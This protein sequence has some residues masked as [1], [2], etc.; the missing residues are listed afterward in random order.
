MRDF[1]SDRLNRKSAM[2]TRENG[3]TME[4]RDFLKKT[5]AG[6]I[7]AGFPGIISG[8]T[9]TNAVKVGLVGAG[10][11]GSGAAAQALSADPNN[12]LT[13]VADI[14]EAIVEQAANR[15]R[16]SE[17]F[18]ARVKID[19]AFF[20]LDA[21]DKV[22][23]SGVDVVLLATPP[24]FRPQH[25]TAAVNANKH[26]FAEKPCATDSPG[27]REVIAAQKLAQ[28]KNLA[29]VSGFC[30]RYNNMIQEAVQQVH[31]GALGRLVA[32]YSTYYTNP[33]KPIPPETE[34]PAGMSDIE[35]QIRHWYNFTWLC[36][37]SLVE[38]AVHN[39][40][41]IMWI[42][43]DQPPASCV[44]VGG[45]AVPANGG[46]IYDHFDANYVYPNG[47]RVFLVNRQATGCYNAT[48][49]YVMGTDGTLLLG[50][51]PARIEAP[52][53][54]VK[55]QF[56][57]EPYDMY[58]REHDVLFS[59]IRSGK[60]KNDDLNLATSTLLAIMGRHAA[61]SGQQVTWEQALNSE[62]SLVPKP[63][64]WN[65]KHEVPGLAQP[66]RSKVF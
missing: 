41:K 34:R 22:I 15:L 39:T 52:G 18:G 65:G 23:N 47:Y 20:G 31:N 24:G 1:V 60:P 19:Q 56:Q 62:V 3:S 8:Q 21:Y 9:V 27:V 11:R 53:G 57:G 61:Y 58:Q 25:L 46:N 55:W 13:A 5:G 43:K 54:Q 16:K 64:D 51:G 66:G 26:V 59:S 2:A 10:G 36:G 50:N 33:V 30:W 38:Q 29:L 48:H 63:V 44:A 37:D 28:T 49:D 12:E 17:R 40:D 45:R 14:D 6:V 42:M 32:H 4:R 35:W 7:A